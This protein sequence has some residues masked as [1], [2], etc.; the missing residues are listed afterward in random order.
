MKYQLGNRVVARGGGRYSARPLSFFT[1]GFWTYSIFKDD[2]ND[3]FSTL[4]ICFM[5]YHRLERKRQNAGDAGSCTAFWIV[6][7]LQKLRKIFL[8][9]RNSEGSRC[10]VL[11]EEFFKSHKR[12]PLVIHPL[13]SKFPFL[14]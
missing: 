8:L 5:M 12:K 3:I 2:M 1:A 13:P 7:C 4:D 10:K 6:N 14:F 11:Y 9:C